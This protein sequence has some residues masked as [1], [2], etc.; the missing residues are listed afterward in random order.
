MII[1]IPFKPREYQK[2]LIEAIDSGRYKR[3]IACWHRR[4]GKDIALWNLIVKKALTEKG[5]YYYFLP[6]FTQ[7]KKII[8]DG[9]NNDGFKFIDYCPKEAT[10]SRNGT[11]LKITLKNGSIIQL[12]GTDTYDSIRGTNPRGCVFSEHAFQN[13]M[14][15]EVV[16]PI[17]KVNGGW[18]VFNSTPNGKNHFYEMFEMAKNND[19]WFTEKLTIKDTGVL[20]EKDMQEEREDG[21]EEDMIQQEYYVSFDVGAKGSYYALLV[22][23]ARKQ[24]RICDLPVEK[25]IQVDIFQDIGRNDS[26]SMGFMQKVGDEIR[27]IDFYED[28][29]KEVAKYIEYVLEMGYHIGYVYLPHDSKQK[30]VEAKNSVWEQWEEAGFR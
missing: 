17:L 30:R 5:L 13:P 14:A 11:E 26:Y 15:W 24:N 19:S 9:I 21:M 3:A 2:P 16:K 4:A 10:E 8:W 18:A 29:G 23:E 28:N 22:E 20:T 1:K 27:F 12:I 7:S 6:T 25:H